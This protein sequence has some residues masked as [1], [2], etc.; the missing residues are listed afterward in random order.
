M[1]ENTELLSGL[2]GDEERTKGPTKTAGMI[3]AAQKAV[4]PFIPSN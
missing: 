2:Y 3:R 1:R 4:P